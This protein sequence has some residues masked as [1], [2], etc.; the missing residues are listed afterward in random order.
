MKQQRHTRKQET[1]K[2]GIKN[3]VHGGTEEKIHNLNK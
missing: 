1:E 2:W 3:R